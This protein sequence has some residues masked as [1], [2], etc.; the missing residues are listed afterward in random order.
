MT[1]AYM[2]VED[3]ID[4]MVT[5]LSDSSTGLNYRIGEINTQ[6]SAIDTARGRPVITLDKFKDT[7]GTETLKENENLFFY[8]FQE[9]TNTD[10]TLLITIPDW[11]TDEMGS[12]VVNVV[13]AVYVED[14]DDGTDPKRKLTRYQRALREVLRNYLHDADYLITAKIMQV[15][16]EL[17]DLRTDTVQRSYY[18]AGVRVIFSFA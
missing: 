11:T 6:K 18:S 16:P 12:E 7:A 5:A 1:I 2:D 10:P 13:F 8:M 4:R 17:M 15:E 3:I 14:V 9:F